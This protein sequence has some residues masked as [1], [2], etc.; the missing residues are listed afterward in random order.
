MV[1]MI[2]YILSSPSAVWAAVYMAVM[3]GALSMFF[4]WLDRRTD[5]KFDVLF[6]SIAICTVITAGFGIALL[7]DGVFFLYSYLRSV[8]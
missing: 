5:L 4:V 8:V 7:L 2:N 3:F 6:F 1:G